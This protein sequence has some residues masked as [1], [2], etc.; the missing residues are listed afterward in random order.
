MIRFKCPSAAL[1]VAIFT[2]AVSAA[3]TAAAGEP[4]AA[5]MQAIHNFKLTPGFL[6]N[7]EAYS[8]EAIQKP[9]ELNPF[10][11]LQKTSGGSQSL[12]ATIAA[13]DAQPGVHEA[14]KRH[15]LT[16]RDVLLGMMTW[17]RAA[18]QELVAQHP[19]MAQNGEIKVDVP[20]SAENMAFYRQHKDEFHRKMT[21]L[22]RAQLARNG[23]QLPSCVQSDE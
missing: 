4:S 10:I 21:E 14:L 12:D 1:L 2:A 6:E 17:I 11:L 13:F 8:A 15:G 3:A 7:Y 18:A 16:A 20:V 5:D 22:G 9:C 19:E 23:G